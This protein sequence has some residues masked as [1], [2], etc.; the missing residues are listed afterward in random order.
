MHWRACH[1]HNPAGLR[2]LLALTSPG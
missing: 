1:V 2:R